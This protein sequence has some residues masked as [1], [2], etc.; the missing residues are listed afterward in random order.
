MTDR[1]MMKNQDEIEK[2]P[3]NKDQSSTRTKICFAAAIAIVLMALAALYIT[4]KTL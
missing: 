4:M 3:S 2:T 1:P